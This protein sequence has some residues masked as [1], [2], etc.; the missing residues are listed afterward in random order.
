MNAKFDLWLLKAVLQRATGKERLPV[1]AE[2]P[3]LCRD[4]CFQAP[5][6]CSA[7]AGRA[8]PGNPAVARKAWP[9]E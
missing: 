9:T 7:E 5:S 1:G 4:E 2:A 3:L 6:G 8:F